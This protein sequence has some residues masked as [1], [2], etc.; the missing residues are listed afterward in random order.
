VSVNK[1]LADF[2]HRGWI[3]LEG[4]SVLISDVERLRA[5]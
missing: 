4:K 3:T 1:A 2:A 5:R